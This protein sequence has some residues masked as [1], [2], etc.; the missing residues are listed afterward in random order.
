[1]EDGETYFFSVSSTNFVEL[2][3][4]NLNSNSI[5][6]DT[7][8]CEPEPFCGD[9][10]IDG[11]LNE[12]CDT[13]GPVFGTINKCTDFNR[14]ISGTLSCNQCSF[15]TTTCNRPPNCGDSKL[16]PQEHCD[17]DLFGSIKIC[18]DLGF[19]SGP[20]TCFPNCFIDTTACKPTPTCGNNVIDPGEECDGNNLGSILDG[21]CNQYSNS[22][23]G[24]ILSC[25]PQTC[26]LDTSKCDGIPGGFCGNGVINIGERCDNTG[27]IFGEITTCQELNFASGTISCSRCELDTFSCEAS[28]RCGN[29]NIDPG[30]ECDGNNLG[31]I[32][33]SCS[34]YSSYFS[35]G[36]ISCD[37]TTC[38]LNTEA[39]FPSPLCGNGF[40]DLEEVCD[41]GIFAGNVDGTC[42]G[43]N[44]DN[45]LS[46]SITCNFDENKEIAGVKIGKCKIDTTACVQSNKC[47]NNVIEPEND[48]ECDGNNFGSFVGTCTDFNSLAFVD[49][50]LAC[51]PQ[52]CK[53]ETNTCEPIP[54]CGNGVIDAGETCDDGIN[55]TNFGPIAGTC[56]EYFDGFSG[57]NLN[58]FNCQIDASSCTGVGSSISNN[59]QIEDGEACD[60]NALGNIDQCTDFGNETFSAGL[61]SCTNQQLDTLACIE[62]GCGNTFIDPGEV[63]DKSNLGGETCTSFSGFIG[64]TLSCI[65]NSC[66][67]DKSECIPAPTCGD[68]N[69][70]PGEVCDPG[71][72]ISSDPVFGAAI[73]QCTDFTNLIGG[74]LL[75]NQ[76]CGF[77]TTSCEEQP[78]CGDGKIDPGEHCD[79]NLLGSIIDSCSDLGFPSGSIKCGD[80]CLLDTSRCKA[81]STCGNGIIDPGEECDGN[82]LGAFS[83]QCIDYSTSFTGGQMSCNNKCLIDT[84]NCLGT[85]GT[86]GDNI[87]NIGETC[88][89]SLFGNVTSCEVFDDFDGGLAPICGFN[90]HLITQACIELPTCGN[91]IIDPDET[92]DGDNLGISDDSCSLYSGFFGSGTITCNENCNLDTFSCESA[93]TCGNGFLD[94]G[95]ICDGSNFG[96]L[97]SLSC[98]DFESRFILG[99]ITCG[100]CEISTREC[101]TNK[102]IITCR[103]RG[104]CRLGETCSDGSQC[105]TGFCSNNICVEASCTDRIKNQDESDVDCGGSCGA[106]NTGKR[107]F[108]NL[109]C[110]SD[111]CTL[112]T[113]GQVDAC[114][115]EKLSRTETGIDC[116]GACPT[117][118]SLGITCNSNSDCES[119]LV[120]TSNKCSEE[121]EEVEDDE[122]RDSDGDGMPDDWE[123]EYGFNPNDSS[124][125]NKDADKEGLTNLEEYRVINKY[126]KSTDPNKADTDGDGYSDKE[127]IDQGTNP[128]DPKSKPKGILGTLI[129][130]FIL[131]IIL[132]TI[133]I[134]V[135]YYMSKSKS[136][137]IEPSFKPTYTAQRPTLRTPIRRTKPKELVKK[138]KQEKRKQ[139]GRLFDTFDKKKPE[140][141][142]LRVTPIEKS[143]E[144]SISFQNS[145]ETRKN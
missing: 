134:G 61:I 133:G 84:T 92:C 119:G 120:C 5:T 93:A 9:G 142:V 11:I 145:K 114:N 38:K 25:N 17:G 41:V 20:I 30:E 99:S 66:E 115:D 76:N 108:F 8:L 112:G 22:F 131:I 98:S 109:D 79:G 136:K 54:S 45:F 42:S 48:E 74:D 89:E 95:E 3:G 103:E 135:Y 75:C 13:N 107:C 44:P 67:F 104:N 111:L 129:L 37:T 90:C 144:P 52:T 29:N 51:N 64:G 39:C 118:C 62:V 70:D 139:R 143:E 105:L 2:E 121:I 36:T 77:D 43:F 6:V 113:C 56:S 53:I 14:F 91:G 100:S 106:C 102:T 110:K 126:G 27:P 72:E 68:G 140:T 59:N 124:D 35:S 85:R 141:K 82:Y 88:D 80:N 49:G 19:L 117:K 55:P 32:S 94:P 16:D 96:N 47:G 18:Q 60:V 83:Q 21:T 12:V 31:V 7:S 33:N 63:C 34:E 28:S 15:D 10:K 78:F 137:A 87:I 26:K 122:D 24:G 123:L 1:M 138:G 71:T 132:A 125:A 58:C 81:I 46:G 57:G 40:L 65:I 86:C 50:N 127:E 23:I 4:S 73:N 130:I 128:L 97:T 101:S 69:I 116:G